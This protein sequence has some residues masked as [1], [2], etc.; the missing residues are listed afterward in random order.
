LGG[1]RIGRRFG[2]KEVLVAQQNG[3]RYRGK[4][5]HGAHI[6]AVAAAAWALRLKIGIAN[7]CQWIFLS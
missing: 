1:G 7:L 6:A 4:T 3:Q 5:Q 2:R